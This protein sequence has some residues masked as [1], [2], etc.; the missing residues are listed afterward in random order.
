MKYPTLAFLMLAALAFVVAV[1]VPLLA[2]VRTLSEV[3][4]A[5]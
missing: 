2:W 5:L 3:G 1:A 4:T